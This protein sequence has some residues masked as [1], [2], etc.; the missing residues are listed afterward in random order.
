MPKLSDLRD[1]GAIEQDADVVA[2][3]HREEVSNP[4]AGEQW[5]GFAQVRIAKFR[6][7]GTCDLALTYRG[8]FVTFENHSGPWPTQ[9]VSRPARTRGFD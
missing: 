7:G 3:I 8:E 6:H 1:S 5:H 4:D 9:P 2:F